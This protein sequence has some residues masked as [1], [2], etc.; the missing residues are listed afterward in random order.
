MS[1]R[2][3]T[4]IV[5]G[6]PALQSPVVL[7]RCSSGRGH[8]SLCR[9][10]VLVE[11]RLVFR[12]SVA[13]PGALKEGQH[14]HRRSEQ[15]AARRRFRPVAE[16]LWALGR[17]V[18]PILGSGSSL[19]VVAGGDSSASDRGRGAHNHC[20]VGNSVIRI[21]QNVCREIPWI[22]LLLRLHRTGFENHAVVV[23]TRNSRGA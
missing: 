18:D 3:W 12:H 21:P 6:R 1:S 11:V 10:R 5:E 9:G 20:C 2:S 14:W 13:G 7:A 19:E 8:P 23:L 22:R 4:G 15:C 17:H 16:S